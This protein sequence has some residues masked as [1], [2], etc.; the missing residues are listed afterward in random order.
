MQGQKSAEVHGLDPDQDGKIVWSTRIGVGGAG[1]GIQWGIAAGDGLVFAGLGESPRGAQAATAKTGL[2]AIDP[3]TG[4][5]VW[6][7]PAPAGLRRPARMLGGAEIAANGDSGRGLFAFDGRACAGARQQDREDHL[8]LRYGARVSYGERNSG[9]RRIDGRHR[10]D[11][12]GRNGVRELGLFAACRAMCC[13]RSVQSD[14]GSTVDGVLG[15]GFAR[16]A[17]SLGIWFFQKA[18]KSNT[19]SL[20]GTPRTSILSRSAE[21]IPTASLSSIILSAY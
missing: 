21:P 16:Q 20:M 15:I 12:G 3:A 11:G 4:K 5:I 10:R 7:E 18:S 17:F 6:N 14:A 13:W 9:E 1:G 8:G 2:F 19:A